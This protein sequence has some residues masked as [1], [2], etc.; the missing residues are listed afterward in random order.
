MDVTFQ[1]GEFDFRLEGAF[2]FSEEKLVAATK[3]VAAAFLDYGGL[4]KSRVRQFRIQKWDHG[5]ALADANLWDGWQ[6]ICFNPSDEFQAVYQLGHEFGHVAMG[7]YK[8]FGQPKNHQWIDEI[9]CGACSLHAT[10]HAAENWEADDATKERFRNQVALLKS[11]EFPAAAV[12]DKPIPVDEFEELVVSSGFHEKMRPYAGRLFELVGGPQI[13]AD[14]P[15]LAEVPP[16]L[17]CGD[18]LQ[19]WKAHCNNV[20]RTACAFEQMITPAQDVTG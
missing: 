12:R 15:G 7:H 11:S 5:H 14:L 18:Y 16:G 10:D 6:I 3:T 17:T 8:R 2:G 1:H 19:T 4:A 9:I 20:G 13:V